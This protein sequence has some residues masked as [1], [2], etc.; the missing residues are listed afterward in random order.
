MTRVALVAAVGLAGCSAQPAEPPAAAAPH[1][2][3]AAPVAPAPGSPA[4]AAPQPKPPEATPPVFEYPPDLAGRAV[5]KATVP[6]APALTPVEK[7]GAEPRPRALPAKL[8]DPEF[9]PKVN[10]A[11]PPVPFAKP[12]GLKPAAPPERVPLDLGRGADRVP[13]RPTFPV[14]AG[15]TERAPDRKSVV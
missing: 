8:L 14:A 10:H 3:I 15:G 5:A 7:F 2:A 9:D 12:A 13:A 1:V 6:P 4:T 11:L